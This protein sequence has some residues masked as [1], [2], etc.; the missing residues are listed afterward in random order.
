MSDT[1][2]N[3]NTHNNPTLSTYRDLRYK[4]LN[5]NVSPVE[6]LREV[7]LAAQYKVSRNTVKKALLMLEK[8]NLITMEPNKG[9]KIRTYSIDEVSEYL[10]F[11]TELEGF[12]GRLAAPLI[13]PAQVTEMEGIMSAMKILL[14][15]GKLLEYSVNNGLFHNI[16]Y[17]ACPN[18]L[19]VSVTVSLKTQMS[20][21]NAKT[22]LVPG[23]NM[24]SY[25]EH[26]AIFNAL[27]SHSSDLTEA[28]L[29]HHVENVR[30][31]FI[32]NFQLL[33]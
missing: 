24:Q 23:R 7:D 10:E 12:I 19:A 8:E 33:F 14:D 26:V 31:T 27:K 16:I 1:N 13:T 32:E 30:K 18:H 21:Y 9:A 5:G 2:Q 6:S 25:E 15:E 20:K 4:I 22:I 29:R 11:R 3:N 28:L 17:E